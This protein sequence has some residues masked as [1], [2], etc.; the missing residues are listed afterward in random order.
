MAVFG[1]EHDICLY[2]P[3]H[4]MPTYIRDIF[5]TAQ[6]TQKIEFVLLNVTYR[7]THGGDGE[8]TRWHF[9]ISET[10]RDFD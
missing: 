8:R 10:K 1:P 5:L 3:L 6:T 2:L 4:I 9:F 7:L